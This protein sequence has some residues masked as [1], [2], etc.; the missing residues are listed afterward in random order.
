MV[1]AAAAAFAGVN[2]GGSV[3]AGYEF[4]YDNDKWTSHVYGQ[5]GDD[6][7]TGK[8]TLTVADDNGYWDANIE[9]VINT[10]NSGAVSA[11]LNVNAMKILED[12]LGFDSEF[13][14]V[15]S[16]GGN[17]RVTALR[18]YSNNSGNN[19]DRVRTNETGFYTGVTLGYGD[20]IQVNFAASPTMQ[21][22]GKTFGSASTVVV[23]DEEGK[24]YTGEVDCTSSNTS[25]AG[26]G[27]LTASV[28]V[29]PYKGIKVSADYAYNGETKG[30]TANKGIVAG[31][32]DFNLGTMLDL[33]F[34]LGASVAE[35]YELDSK[36]NVVA[37]TVYGGYDMV[38]LAA[39]YAYLKNDGVDGDHYL[40]LGADFQ[41]LSD[42]S[43]N[44]YGG[45]N[46]VTDFENQYFVGGGVSY[47]LC[48]ITGS[49]GVEYSKG[50]S[51]NYD[52]TGLCIVPSVAVSF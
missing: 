40:Y 1:L 27:D 11:D 28:L 43:F 2:F 14:A 44:V 24:K 30:S 38:S 31:A 46:N 7:D 22:A 42:L 8:L 21:A 48:G 25:Y 19:F 33:G 29:T 9:G 50:S 16:F 45:A 23:T 39:E 26:A 13:S 41:V 35:R 12:T 18:A 32:A 37:A 3:V 15:V 6:T 36:Y 20:F 17:D 34:N 4:N 51:Y 5:D 49:L 10:D 52:H 47:T